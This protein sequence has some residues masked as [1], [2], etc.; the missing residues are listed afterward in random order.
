MEMFRYDLVLGFVFFFG[1]YFK[2]I[3][4]RYL[5]LVLAK[6]G[7]S[8]LNKVAEKHITVKD[9]KKFRITAYQENQV[10]IS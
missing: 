7:S 3:E 8:T 10:K 6:T 4:Y 5:V 2:G 9:N 1:R